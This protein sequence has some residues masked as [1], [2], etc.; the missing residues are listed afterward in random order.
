VPDKENLENC[1]FNFLSTTAETCIQDDNVN[2]IQSQ[3]NSNNTI[4]PINAIN[5]FDNNFISHL[6]PDSVIVTKSN[7][8]F[9]TKLLKKRCLYLLF[10]CNFSG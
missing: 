9:S 8:I 2:S 1:P 10:L 7:H 3:T 5:H 4:R 6:Q